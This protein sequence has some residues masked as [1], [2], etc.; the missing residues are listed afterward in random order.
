MKV[1]VAPGVQRGFELYSPDSFFALTY[2]FLNETLKLLEVIAI[3]LEINKK[4]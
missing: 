2:H 1:K 3:T 4:S